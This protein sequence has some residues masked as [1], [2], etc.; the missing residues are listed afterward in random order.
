M[1]IILFIIISFFYF[2]P[3]YLCFKFFTHGVILTH[4]VVGD[5]VYEV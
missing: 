5:Y 4:G 3:L 1:R 2:I